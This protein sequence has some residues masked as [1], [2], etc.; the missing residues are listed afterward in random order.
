MT[1]VLGLTG[2][3]A[4]GKSTVS[5]FFSA[6]GYPIID[7]DRISHDLVKPGTKVWQ[8]LYRT[9]GNAVF[10]GQELDR[11][12]LGR[13]VFS[14]PKQLDTLNRIMQPAIRR[15][16]CQAIAN[17]KAKNRSLIILDAPLL[18]EQGYQTL[19]DQVMVVTT[20]PERQLKRLMLRDGYSKES[21]ERRIASQWSQTKKIQLAD[22]VVENSGSIDETRAQVLKWLDNSKLR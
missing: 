11:K 6:L 15:T 20:T 13:I 12:A 22:I 17:L 21:A 7:A 19:V 2:G 1:V 4:T 10:H 9:F 16:I 18:L 8:Q 3:I 5:Q 14:D